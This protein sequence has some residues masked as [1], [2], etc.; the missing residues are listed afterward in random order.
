MGSIG[1][2]FRGTSAAVPMTRSAFAFMLTLLL[3]SMSASVHAQTA[4]EPVVD[5]HP[6]ATTLPPGTIATI[7]QPPGLNSRIGPGATPRGVAFPVAGQLLQGTRWRATQS[8]PAT[9]APTCSRGWVQLLSLEAAQDVVPGNRDVWI[10]RGDGAATY[11]ALTMAP[12]AAANALAAAAPAAAAPAATAPA[13][14]I[15]TPA[16]PPSAPGAIIAD[17]TGA[18][19]VTLNWNPAADAS[20]SGVAGYRIERC[21]GAGCTDF[22]EIG[23]T[24]RPPFA[25]TR[26]SPQTTYAYR[27]RAYDVAGNNSA[28]A[29][30][31]QATTQPPLQSL[32]DLAI[33]D[34]KVPATG[35]VGAAFEATAMVINRGATASAAYRLAFYF[36]DDR[37]T[38]FS[39]TYCNMPALPSGASGPCRG[40]VAIPASLAP[41]SYWIV[42]YAD[43]LNNVA[44]KDKTNNSA[45]MRIM[46]AAATVALAPTMSV[47][48]GLAASTSGASSIRLAWTAPP[49]GQP[50]PDGYKIERCTG[51]GCT[52][53]TQVATSASPAHV[54]NGLVAGTTY[55]YRVRAFDNKGNSSNYS[56]VVTAVLR[57]VAGT[58]NFDRMT[59]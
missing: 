52:M 45:G 42:A 10:C 9:K 58:L 38:T 36:T 28:Y 31:G 56:N 46:L 44:E 43:D 5:P 21:A 13:T 48:T 35:S 20:R 6:G 15:P 24:P 40:T 27:I 23:T 19:S 17:A 16:S 32:P 29:A 41:G 22:R 49:R 57:P 33:A 50:V 59:Q 1:K 4:T 39:G 53:F 3:S 2:V 26:V 12:D 8:T 37:V 34:L 54:D 7:T 14:K 25:D 55:V 18:D 47:P 30:A 51:S 11:A